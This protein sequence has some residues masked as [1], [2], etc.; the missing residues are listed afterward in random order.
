MKTELK[1]GEIYKIMFPF[2]FDRRYSTG[3][4]KY[5]LVLQS[6]DYFQNYSTTVILLLTS[7]SEA[8]GLDHVV[9][10]DKGTTDLPKTS[11]IDCSQPYTIKKSIF[12]INVFNFLEISHP[13][14]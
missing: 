12:L 2:T 10:I 3:K 14:N 6:G 9:K 5:A 13:K 7:N 11:Y 1:R 8:D 4:L